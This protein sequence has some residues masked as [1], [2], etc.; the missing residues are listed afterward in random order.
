MEGRRRCSGSGES[1]GR[2]RP[3]DLTLSKVALEMGLC[4]T[5]FPE[6]IW[7]PGRM[8]EGDTWAVPRFPS[9]SPGKG[10]ESR[11]ASYQTPSPGTNRCPRNDRLADLRAVCIFC[12]HDLKTGGEQFV[13]KQCHQLACEKH[14]L[15]VNKQERD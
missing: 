12:S 4:L 10:I 15:S 3:S 1:S 8:T 9:L 7:Y 11:G 6:L 2:T 14:F 5:R 13:M